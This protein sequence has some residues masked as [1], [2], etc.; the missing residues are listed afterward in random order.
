MVTIKAIIS[1]ELDDAFRRK[2]VER[3]GFR[4]GAISEAI[5]EAIENWIL[6]NES[7]NNKKD[8]PFDFSNY[9]EKTG[10][11]FLA[12]KDD[13]VVIEADSL[14]ELWDR[15]PSNPE[16]HYTLITPKTVKSKKSSKKRQLGWNLVRK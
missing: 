4:R 9:V 8:T 2:V 1:D 10:K 11:Q 15:L 14:E 13:Q 3:F 6:F 7:N 12:I 16:E 5:I